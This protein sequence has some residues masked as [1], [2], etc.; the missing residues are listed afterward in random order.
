MKF[1]RG[2]EEER[3]LR[4]VRRKDGE[5][6]SPPWWKS[7]REITGRLASIRKGQGDAG[8]NF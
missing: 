6:I 5:A 1:K 7:P 2:I 3:K 4:Q 8:V